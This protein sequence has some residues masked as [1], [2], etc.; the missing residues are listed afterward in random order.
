MSLDQARAFVSKVREDK[1][2]QQRIMSMETDSAFAAVVDIG[3][4][5]GYEF[6][7][8]EI[9]QVWHETHQERGGRELSAKE[10]DGLSAAGTLYSFQQVCE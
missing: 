6:T 8:E 9:R 2:L 7:D 4:G 1:E 5:E 3:K 10:L